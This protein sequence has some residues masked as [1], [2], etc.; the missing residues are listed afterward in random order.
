MLRSQLALADGSYHHG[1]QPLTGIGIGTGSVTAR[2]CVAK[3][4]SEALA[5]L[6]PGDI[7][8][9]PSTNPAF[10][11]ALSIAGGLV[12]EQGG[13]ISH[14]AVSARELGLPA[15]IGAAGAVAA[16]PDRSLITV[17]AD[18]GLVRR[19]DATALRHT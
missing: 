2:A 12:V 5:L 9:T 11:Y 13:Y 18:I 4:A 10:N 15:V 8:V 6:Q 14:A 1:T 7:L 16:I 17:D 3:D 19:L